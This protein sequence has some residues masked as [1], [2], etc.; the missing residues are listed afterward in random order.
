M[1]GNNADA[2]YGTICLSPVETLR[3]SARRENVAGTYNEACGD[4]RRTEDD[5]MSDVYAGRIRPLA[6]YI[7][8]DFELEEE[9]RHHLGIDFRDVGHVHREPLVAH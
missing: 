6:E 3:S 7:H 5:T 9:E 4:M 8:V 1:N 2:R